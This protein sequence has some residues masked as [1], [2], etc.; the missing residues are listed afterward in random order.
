ME[1][2]GSKVK[3]FMEELPHWAQLA[4]SL[5]TMVFGLGV[6]YNDVATTKAQV[7]KYG[8]VATQQVRMA[9]EIDNLHEQIAESQAT[10]QQTNESVNK[11][12]DSVDKLSI[13]VSRL[14]GRLWKGR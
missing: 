9:G 5:G 8:D 2:K 3:L 11:L 14:E 13:S 7:D 1:G 10:Q 6:M 12:S 4:I